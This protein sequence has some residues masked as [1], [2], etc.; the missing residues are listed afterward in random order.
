MLAKNESRH[1]RF[2]RL[3]QNR[4][5]RTLEQLRLVS[6]LAS[7]R[8]ENTPE[9]AGE[10]VRLLDEA[11]RRVA[12]VFGV[13]YASRIG[14]AASRTT[15][16]ARAIGTMLKRPSVLDEVECMKLIEHI[17]ADR[18]LEAIAILRAAIA[19]GSPP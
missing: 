17:R 2:L 19:G 1:E 10:V 18:K 3:A 12:E 4:L 5:G 11:V 15:G 16:G 7:H 8:Y 6:Q 9:E 13:E 14:K